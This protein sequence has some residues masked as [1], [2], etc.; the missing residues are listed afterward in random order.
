MSPARGGP[1]SG[2]RRGVVQRVRIA[3]TIA[4]T[5]AVTTV[6]TNAMTIAATAP[7]QPSPRG[8]RA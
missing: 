5:I 2:L 7:S 6:V 4:E 1:A 8:S 3:G